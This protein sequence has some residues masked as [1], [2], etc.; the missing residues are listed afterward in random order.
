M[1]QHPTAIVS[2]KAQIA[3]DVQ[4]GPYSIIEDDVVIGRGTI[5]DS[6]VS[7]KNGARIG[8]NVMI[9]HAAA[10][11]GPPQDLKF[12]GEK[13]ELIVGDNTI[14]RE[15]VTLNRGTVAHGKTEIGKNCLFMAYS[16]AAHDCIIGD[17]VIIA[18]SVQMGGHVEIGDYAI[19]GGATVIHQFSHVGEHCM[20]GGGFRITQ[21]ILPYSTVAGYPLRCLGLNSVGLR[22]RGFSDKTIAALKKMFR[23]LMSKKLNTS[24]ALVKIDEEVEKIPE[25]IKVLEFIKRSERGVVK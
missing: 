1:I 7:I 22:R 24:Q 12:A 15:F 25:V 19:I 3:D 8:E 9:Y 4:V 2:S 17:N 14:I 11:A 21:D 5:I 18:N 10:V 20:V 23:F 6:S 13:T 16:H